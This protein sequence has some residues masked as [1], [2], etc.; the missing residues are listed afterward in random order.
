MCAS[1]WSWSVH[2]PGR[3]VRLSGADSDPEQIALTDQLFDAAFGELSV[4]AR[5]QP[6]L[7]VGD[8]NVEPTRIP[9]LAK[10]ISA[11]LWVDPVACW[12]LAGGVQPSS[13]CMREWGSGGGHRRDFM[14]G[15]PLA[16]AAVVSCILLS[17]L[18]LIAVGGHPGLLS[19]S[20][21]LSFGLPLGCLL[22]I[23]V[24]VPSRLGLGFGGCGR[25]WEVFDERLQFMSRQDALQQDESL[26]AGDVSRAWLVW[27]WAAEVALADAFRFSGGPVPTRSL[28]LGR[29]SALF[30]VVWLG[31]PLVKRARSNA[32]DVV[33]VADVFLY[34]DSSIAP[35]LNM[36]RRFK[37]VMDV[38]GATIRYGVSLFRS[39][40]LTAQWDRILAFGPLCPVTHDDLDVVRGL[41]IGDFY[42]QVVSG[43]HH[44]L[45][46]FVVV[47]RRDEA[48]RGWRNWIREDPMVHPKRWL[49]PDL[50][51]PDPFLQCKPH[52]HA[53]WF[54]CAC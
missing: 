42:Y 26:D 39:V 35:L 28:V 6:C 54:W 31:G 18:F 49:R 9:C 53:W 25:V 32:A 51:P 27:S 7:L 20:R 43:V 3:F 13:T 24:G 45:S 23:R 10:G 36:R 15:C 21:V 33:D 48:V 44:R 30:R 8:F 41:G 38:L 47:H 40:E 17:G 52:F 37:A 22:L 50:V 4:V 5:G 46:N 19:L 2:A 11:G 14:V 34:R 1:S 12:A 16:A 29:C